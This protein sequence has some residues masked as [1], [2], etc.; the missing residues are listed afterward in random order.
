MDGC[1]YGHALIRAHSWGLS[2]LLV[3]IR[4][5]M[6]GPGRGSGRSGGRRA[7]G[8][9]WERVAR[10]RALGVA[11][12]DWRTE[13]PPGC[14]QARAISRWPCTWLVGDQVPPTTSALRNASRRDAR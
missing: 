6:R 14:R 9:G 5:Q 1:R 10:A 12:W 7:G 2:S 4:G 3:L 8:C 13:V 11:A